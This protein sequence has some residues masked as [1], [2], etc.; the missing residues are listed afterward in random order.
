MIVG[1]PR[2]T[3]P[4]EQRVAIV[5]ASMKTLQRLNLEL[6]VESGAGVGAGVSDADYEQAGATIVGSRDD[7]FAKADIIAMVRAG[8]ANPDNASDLE[9][10][11]DDQTMVA[12]A[13]PLSDPT[14]MN[15]WA[16]TGGRL[17]A[18]EL[19][20]RITRAQ[21]M[22]VLS[23]M[24]SLAGYKA[25]L[26]GAAALPK[27]FPMMMTAA[28]TVKPARVFVLGAGVAGL[29]AI[30]TAKRLG[31][32]VSA[33]DV[34]PAVKEQVESLGG[35]FVDTTTVSGEGKG[36]YAKALDEDAK[37]AQRELVKAVLKESDVVITTAAVPGKKAP[38]LLT[39]EMVEVMPA[40]SVIVDLA[41]ERG[42]NCELTKPDEEV[43]SG[44][45]RIIGPANIPS[46]LA[47]DAS[48]MYSNNLTTFLKEFVSD[49]KLSIELENEVVAGTLVYQGGELVH[50]FVRELA[51]LP[52]WKPTMA[53]E[54]TA[55]ETDQRDSIP[56]ADD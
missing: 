43:V 19:V 26:L 25:V 12:Q 23:S 11:R 35:R 1:V 3:F 45:V 15:S 40:G 39:A 49:G 48:L 54:Q 17:F 21:S 7:V 5:P 44:G 4:D 55:G 27:Q 53:E 9:R 28:G 24:A 50:N 30:A 22:D 51:G 8:I 6:I 33:T 32:L 37:R 56:L 31:A 46:T 20:P 10:L 14:Q 29:Q 16:A 42:G 41:A 38:T 13:D 47:R 18:L 36:G 34:R 2:E 52:K